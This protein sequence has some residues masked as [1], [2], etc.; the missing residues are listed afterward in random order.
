MDIGEIS[1]KIGSSER[2]GHSW[3]VGVSMKILPLILIFL[4]SIPLIIALARNPADIEISKFKVTEDGKLG[5]KE[6]KII[7]SASI[8]NN[9][10]EPVRV[11][12]VCNLSE[13]GNLIDSQEQDFSIEG[14]QD[15]PMEFTFDAE[16]GHRYKIVA[17]FYKVN[18]NGKY[19][20][21]TTKT[22]FEKT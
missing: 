3:E 10:Q 21:I 17:K 19:E 6:T 13:N 9:L 22:D 16:D 15:E 12:V 1:G 14:N 7:V 20:L 18:E 2:Y 11:H 8:E 4:F 5:T